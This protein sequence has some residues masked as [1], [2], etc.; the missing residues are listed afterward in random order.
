[1]Q[2]IEEVDAAIKVFTNIIDILQ[3]TKDEISVTDEKTVQ[4]ELDHL[5]KFMG[6]VGDIEALLLKYLSGTIVDRAR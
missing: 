6:S 2:G 4:Y 3:I 1:M 5:R